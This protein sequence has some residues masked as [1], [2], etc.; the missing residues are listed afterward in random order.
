MKTFPSLLRHLVSRKFNP[1][2]IQPADDDNFD[3]YRDDKARCYRV[4]VW[5]TVPFD[6][7]QPCPPPHPP[8]LCPQWPPVGPAEA[9]SMT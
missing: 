2:D 9:D 8:H 4:Q 5:A 1:A 3:F 7:I 6:D